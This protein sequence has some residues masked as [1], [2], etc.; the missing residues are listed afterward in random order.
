MSHDIYARMHEAVL[1]AVP[2]SIVLNDDINARVAIGPP[3]DASHGDM[4]TN[5]A[6]VL[7]TR[8]ARIPVSWPQRFPRRC[9]FIPR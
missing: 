8:R 9:A 5:A 7:A 1:Q 3:R 6:M 4:T 2:S